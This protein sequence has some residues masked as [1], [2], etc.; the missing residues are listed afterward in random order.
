MPVPGGLADLRASVL[1]RP[2][3][4]TGLWSYAAI[5]L[6]AAARREVGL[7]FGALAGGG[8]RF[9]LSWR[10]WPNR[11]RVAGGIAA[12]A[13]WG[14]VWGVGLS[15]E[16]QPFDTLLAPAERLTVRAE[17]SNWLTSRARVSV[18]GGADRWTD[19]GTFG[20]AATQ[21]RL[22]APNRLV[23]GT[24]ELSVWA[25]PSRFSAA[26]ATFAITRSKS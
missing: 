6:Q 9:D 18:R 17:L 19:S 12:P 15:S 11:P 2:L 3:V 4:P 14:G 7:T 5:A 24:V 10:F 26:T 21:L 25:G 13:P 16:R 20:H 1:E 23:E 8:E 22:A